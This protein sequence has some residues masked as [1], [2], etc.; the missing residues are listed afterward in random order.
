MKLKRAALCLIS[1]ALFSHSAISHARSDTPA[2]LSGSEASSYDRI[3]RAIE[4][5]QWADAEALIDSAPGGA[6]TE[7]ARAELY[8]APGS[9]VVPLGKLLAL[10]NDAP[11]LPQADQLG[12]LA[13]TRGATIL[14][15]RP[16]IQ[17][18]SWLGA[19]PRRG[20]PRGVDD[21]MASSISDRVLEYIRNDDPAGAEAL[22]E[23]VAS[24]MSDS[25]RTEWRQR[26]AWSYYIENDDTN[27]RRMA[28]QARRGVGEW[29]GHAEW[30]L[31]LANWRLR[32]FAA[33]EA[34]F[35]RATISASN[36]EM[37]AAA[38]YWGGRASM[39]S[40]Q[41]H[42]VQAKFQTAAQFH[43]TLYGI[44]AAEALG[45]EPMA[46]R[47]A[48]ATN[49]NWKGLNGPNLTVA[50]GLAQIGRYELADEALRHRARI[51]PASDYPAL[52]ALARHLG[53]PETQLYLGQNGPAG[54]QSDSFARYPTAG[55][56]PASGWRVDRSLVFAHALQESRFRARAE[57][58]AGA[59]GLM[60]VMPATARGMATQ[61]DRIAAGSDLFDP[62]TNLE[63]G[64]TYLE[65]LR[66][67]GETDG[68]LPKVMAAYNAGPTPVGRWK[69]EVR[70]MGDPLLFI[71]SIPYW[72]TRDYVGTVL[73]NYWMYEQQEKADSDSR[74]GIAQNMW[75]RFPGMDGPKAVRMNDPYR[76]DRLAAR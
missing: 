29:V 10:L 32:D 15:D 69:T 3:F 39:A 13:Q 25:A 47:Q 70:D 41:A 54:S 21:G 19:S 73:R 63:Y 33:A 38:Y 75:P 34:A 22:V 1:A 59:R 43:E 6:M 31:G 46:R 52:I 62:A 68:L 60:Q 20:K 2:A 12:R 7:M 36:D 45:V 30:V 4:N 35:D 57:S 49:V 11:W 58:P 66:D 16:V 44:L 40:G 37:R 23:S 28:E 27:A 65:M 64:Q 5:G 24:S 61:N 71:E 26:V 76:E 17:K 42:R 50:T 48:A 67:M 56:T 9:P 53:L 51:G 14:P 55:W 18:L 72:E 74:T 8:L